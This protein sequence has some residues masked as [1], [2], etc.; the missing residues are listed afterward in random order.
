MKSE[1][2]LK[3]AN[4][5]LIA[6]E[7][8][9][10]AANQ[11]LEASN[12]QLIASEQSIRKSE[13]ELTIRN[14]IAEVFLTVADEQMYDEV[15][16]IV[17]E[18]MESE[19]CIFGYID[20]EGALVV[21]SM[22]EQVWDQCQVMDR[23]KAIHKETWGDIN[24]PRTQAIME[25]RTILSNECSVRTPE[26]HISIT[27]HISLPIIHRGEV[28]GLIQVANK[29]TDYNEQ[30]IEL[31][32]TIGKTIAPILAARIQRNREE[33]ERRRAEDTLRHYEHIV[34]TTSD[35]LALLDNKFSYIAANQAYLEAFKL[36]AEELIGNTVSEVFGEKFFEE[37]IKPHAERCLAGQEVNYQAWFDFPAYRPRYM[38]IN[39]Y[40]YRGVDKK[41]K[42]YVVNG[43]NITDRKK[44]ENELENIFILSPDMVAVCTTEGKFLKVNPAW[45]KVIGY[46]QKEL[47]DLG[48]TKLVHPDDVE[49]TA[50]EVA[51]QLK[52]SSVVNFINRYKCKD[53]SYKTFEWQATFAEDGIVHATARDITDRKQAEER[54]K[55][56][57]VLLEKAVDEKQKEM[58]ILMERLIRQ[59][60]LATIG[61]IS[62]NIA[63]ELRNPL[64]VIKQSIYFLENLRKKN[65][66]ESLTSK[67]KEHFELVIDE[68]NGSNKVISDL[69]QLT[70]I[71]PLKKKQIDL[72][73][74]ILELLD[75]Y[76]LE[77]NT[78][79]KIN[80]KPEPFLIWADPIQM[81]QVLL[82]LLS[83]ATYEIT[84][85][86]VVTISAEM[87][88][89][90]KKCLMKI[91]DDG[92]GIT[93]ENLSK[94][95]EPLY[96][97]KVK[98]IGLGLNI[99]KKII[100]N[101]GGSISLTSEIGKGT[102]VKI[103]LP[104]EILS[105][106]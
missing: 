20:E 1:I 75:R 44:I 35:M 89:K 21:P 95:F 42:G 37:L 66:L 10:K 77:K 29:E 19:Y 17:L 33:K 63:H 94:V 84:N 41:I 16:K 39:Y 102:T 90:S 18:V 27:R 83:N 11:Q 65:K 60:K 72:R 26:G 2:S 93:D 24:W 85:K 80:L 64:S 30:D 40:P 97:S 61:Q 8:Q 4:Q 25:K 68:I 81:R 62:G 76:P 98:G 15:L 87:L 56:Q 3:A 71:E 105:E 38:D 51:K 52:G 34:S 13:R 79:L 45:E 74:V 49:K 91:H 31:F 5:Q 12:Q 69:L 43:R 47:L 14:K 6:S 9:L 32:E 50:T 7:Q 53:G 70:R 55:N 96:T 67:V 92:P 57:N 99:C 82:N 73:A 22:T 28:V 106:K 88:K 59:E 23:S 100:E 86:R 101:H 46:T 104:Y 36:T 58:E 54:I 48:W 78:Q 103:E